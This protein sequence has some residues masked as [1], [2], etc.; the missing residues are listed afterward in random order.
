MQPDVLLKL[1]KKLSIYYY[2]YLVTLVKK[3]KNKKKSVHCFVE[4]NDYVSIPIII[5]SVY[6]IMHID[7]FH[8]HYVCI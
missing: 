1:D 8:Y 2:T 3:M 6:H 5:N 7:F 4:L